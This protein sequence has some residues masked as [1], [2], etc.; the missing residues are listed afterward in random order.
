MPTYT[1]AGVI[2][3]TLT[4]QRSQDLV[5]VVWTAFSSQKKGEAVVSGIRDQ[6]FRTGFQRVTYDTVTPQFR[7]RSE[8]GAIFNSPFTSVLTEW[9]GPI[10]A[11]WMWQYKNV[12]GAVAGQSIMGSGQD[13]RSQLRAVNDNVNFP[14]PELDVYNAKVFAGTQAWAAV[15]QPE[16]DAPVFIAEAAETYRMLVRPWEGLWRHLERQN[17]NWRLTQKRRNP[18]ERGT[19]Y[20][21]MGREAAQ[22]MSS[23]YLANRYGLQ[24]F[25]RD[26]ESSLSILRDE[27]TWLPRQ[28]AR[29]SAYIPSQKR[30]WGGA[31]TNDTFFDA[32]WKVKATREISVRAGLLYTY[33]V[34]T[35][36]RVGLNLTALPRAGW[37]A[38]PF[39]FVADWIWNVGD[40]LAALES[41]TE[42]DILSQW[43]TVVDKKSRF[44]EVSGSSPKSSQT[45][46]NTI[47]G[48]I[49]A[50]MTLEETVKYREPR[51]YVG[52]ARD[53][54]LLDMSKEKWRARSLDVAAFASGFIGASK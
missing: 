50:E 7:S 41:K 46:L 31:V 27:P 22:L 39:S 6:G 47:T 1:L 40:V 20:R 11:G 43:T 35:T 4:R 26:I 37:E 52:F 10:P 33:R 23:M 14:H 15:Q 36:S 3:D 18:R 30:E 54:V 38:I 28:T 19:Y 13:S 42:C 5:G 8:K 2:P 34:T 48:G 44:S 21:N 9:K 51:T 49:N 24:P 29:G 53:P 45:T 32:Q 16:F 25:L 17:K 12:A